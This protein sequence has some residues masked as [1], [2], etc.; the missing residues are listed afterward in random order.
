MDVADD[1][2]VTE[3][4][5]ESP[6]TLTGDTPI[7]ERLDSLITQMQDRFAFRTDLSLETY[8]TIARAVYDDQDDE[9]IAASL[10]IDAP[11]VF[12]ARLD[13]HLVTPSDRDGPVP[14]EAVRKHIQQD[15]SADL[16]ERFDVETAVLDRI[17][18]IAKAD[19]AMRQVN[20]RFRDAFDD[21]LG[22]GDVAERFT[23]DV[24]DD[25]LEDATE[26]MEIE[27]AF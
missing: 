27:T 24:T 6:G 20:Y 8:R 10:D 12:A 16:A 25:G 13:L 3:E 15:D 1:A 22:D 11:T 9:Q 14:I 17:S 5:Q 18:A 7:D 2:T 23:D 19:I 26:G 21:I 4:Q